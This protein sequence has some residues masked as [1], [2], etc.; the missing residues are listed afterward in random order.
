MK[1]ADQLRRHGTIGLSVGADA[2]NRVEVKATV[3]VG[4]G[5]TGALWRGTSAVTL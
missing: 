5:A 1:G 3:D 4:A 2:E